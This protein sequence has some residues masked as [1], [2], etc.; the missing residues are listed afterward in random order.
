MNN[1]QTKIQ[2]KIQLEGETYTIGKNYSISFHFIVGF[3]Y[4]F[5]SKFICKKY[6]LFGKMFC[7]FVATIRARFTK[8]HLDPLYS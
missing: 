8:A 5:A 1:N 3:T 7:N 4:V 2:T 6:N